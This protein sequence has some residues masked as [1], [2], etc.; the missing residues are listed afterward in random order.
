[1][2]SYAIHADMLLDVGNPSEAIWRRAYEL[3]SSDDAFA[4]GVLEEMNLFTNM[5]ECF[6][7]NSLRNER[8]E[9]LT[10]AMKL[11]IRGR[12]NR[13]KA[14]TGLD[15]RKTFTDGRMAALMTPRERSAANTYRRNTKASPYQIEEWMWQWRD[16]PLRLKR[17]VYSHQYQ[18]YFADLGSGKVEAMY[19]GFLGHRFPEAIWYQSIQY[20]KAVLVEDGREVAMVRFQSFDY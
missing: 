11:F 16:R 4:R 6:D 14:A 10:E 19:L 7:V 20:D 8:N 3:L 18:E 15:A 12:L 17:F 13:A 1:V 5:R 9:Y 2:E